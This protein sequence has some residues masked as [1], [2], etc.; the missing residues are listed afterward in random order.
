MILTIF[1]HFKELQK[2]INVRWNILYFTLQI[3]LH[4]YG[5]L[6]HILLTKEESDKNSEVM[7]KLTVFPRS[8]LEIICGFLKNFKF[9][10][11]LAHEQLESDKIDNNADSMNIKEMKAAGR[12]YI[13]KNNYDFSPKYCA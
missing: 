11:A 6:A 1:K 2:Y 12:H 9:C 3:E 5:H 8:D 4:Y 10:S 7:H 13:E